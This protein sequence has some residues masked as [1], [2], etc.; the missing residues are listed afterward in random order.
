MQ[1][2]ITTTCT[3]QGKVILDYPKKHFGSK[4][5]NAFYGFPSSLYN[6]QNLTMKQLNNKLQQNIMKRLNN[7]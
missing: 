6:P 4:F 5:I 2:S 3:K 1:V 7:K